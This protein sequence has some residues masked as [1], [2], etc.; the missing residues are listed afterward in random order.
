MTHLVLNTNEFKK[1]SILKKYN[2]NAMVIYALFESLQNRIN[3]LEDLKM[4]ND[5][6]Q[7][8]TD[9]IYSGNDAI[10]KLKDIVNQE[11][12]RTLSY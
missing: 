1:Y 4:I 2:C 12:N 7:A 5:I 10:A 8:K 6:Q 9:K 3:Q 11:I